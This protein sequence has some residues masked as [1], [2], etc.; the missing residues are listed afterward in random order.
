M[1]ADRVNQKV[2]VSI[3]SLAAT[4]IAVLDTT[5]VNV[6][7]PTIGRD[8]HVR[9][10]SV[11]SVAIGFLVSL[12]VVM[13]VSGWL[14]DRFGNKR[15]MLFA[16]V[17]FTVASALCGAASS[18]GQLVI[19]RVVQGVGG[20]VLMPVG[21]AMLYQTFPPAER[22]RVSSIMVI[23]SAF[24]PALGPVVGGLFTTDVSWR[25]VF[26]VNV[27]V[28]IAAVTF[29]VLFLGDPRQDRPGRFDLLGFVLAGAGLSLLMYGVSEGPPRGWSDPL[30]IAASCCGAAGLVLLVVVELRKAHPMLDFRLYADRLFRST[31]CA[32]TLMSI[33]FFG[34]V[35]MVALFYQYGLGYS[36]LQS[37]LL[38]FPQAI[39]IFTGGQLVTRVFYRRF[40]PRRLMVLG[41]TLTASMMVVL[42]T[43]GP[44]T[45]PWTIRAIAFCLGGGLSWIFVP[46][47]TASFAT[48]PLARIARGTTLFQAQQRLGAA[49]GVAG[50]TTVATAVGTTHVVRGRVTANLTAYRVG[51]LAA[52]AVMLATAVVSALVSDADAV[53]TM[54]A[55]RAPH[56][57]EAVALEA[58]ALG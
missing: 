50:I 19:F 43:I 25:W 15:V 49:L 38:V 46:S 29:G 32:I 34:V 30:V 58:E 55:R 45:S 48:V 7:I 52:A 47:S 23:P 36:A 51:F 44:A 13:P 35:Y 39:G 21:M 24:A 11:D 16:I 3:V 14:G 31:L 2:A 20:G 42:T 6:T 12:A 53:E 54:S 28:G 40:G 4:F 22:I 57:G 1:F 33:S 27:P 8:F 17:L 18:L 5:I 9:T 10:A 56:P 37:G 26:Y 41:A